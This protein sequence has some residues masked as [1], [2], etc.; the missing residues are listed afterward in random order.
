[1]TIEGEYHLRDYKR[2]ENFCIFIC[3]WSGN[4][5]EFIYHLNPSNIK[6]KKHKKQIHLPVEIS[7]LSTV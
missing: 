4:P 3:P 6:L 1:M 2:K 7:F 5:E